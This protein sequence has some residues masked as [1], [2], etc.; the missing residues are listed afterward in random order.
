MPE[1]DDVSKAVEVVKRGF[2][3]EVERALMVKVMEAL[4]LLLR[5]VPEQFDLVIELNT[6]LRPLEARRMARAWL[7][8][9]RNR[10][11]RKLGVQ[12]PWELIRL[13]QAF[14]E[15]GLDWKLDGLTETDVGIAVLIQLSPRKRLKVIRELKNA[16]GD[17]GRDWGEGWVMEKLD[18]DALRRRL[19]E[20]FPKPVVSESH[21]CTGMEALWFLRQLG[22]RKFVGVVRADTSLS[23]QQAE[24]FVRCWEVARRN[25]D[26]RKLC[27]DRPW[28]LVELVGGFQDAGLWEHLETVEDGDLVVAALVELR[29]KQRLKVLRSAGRD[30]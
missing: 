6:S 29:P 3:G 7:V 30:R 20:V 28:E 16:A 2:P 4:G 5:E 14:D 23:L 17:I 22:V 13:V 8:M 1:V 9:E 18:M 26:L 27:L 19:S 21:I 12:Q 11:L 10:E 24:L 15:V 25:R